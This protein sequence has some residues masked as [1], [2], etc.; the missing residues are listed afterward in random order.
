MKKLLTILLLGIFLISF[1]SA[2]EFDNVLRYEEEDMKVTIINYFNIPLLREDIGIVELK[3]HNSVDE[4]IKVGVGKRV[5][6]FYNFYNFKEIYYNGL[7]EVIFTNINTGEI[8]ERDY[9]YVY[10]TNVTEEFPIMICEEVV[11]KNGTT[12]E[13][14]QEGTKFKTREMWI[15]YNSK[16]I[17]TENIRIGIDVEVRSGDNIDGVWVIAGEEISKHAGWIAGDLLDGVRVAFQFEEASGNLVDQTGNVSSAT[18]VNV[19]YQISGALDFAYNFTGTGYVPFPDANPWDIT[20]EITINGWFNMDASI[21]TGDAP[22]IIDKGGNSGNWGLFLGYN[23]IAFVGENIITNSNETADLRGTG[24]RMA[25]VTFDDT[26]NE[27]RFYLDGVNITNVS[28][29]SAWDLTP[30][31]EDIRIGDWENGSGNRFMKG[32]IDELTIWDEVKTSEQIERLYDDGL[33]CGYGNTNCG[34]TPDDPPNINL[35]S[36]SSANYTTSQNLEINFT[37]WDDMKLDNV[38]LYVN[39]ILNQTNTSGINNTDYIFD[40]F[41]ENGDYIILGKATDNSSQSTNSSS[42]LIKIDTL[43]PQFLIQN[44]NGT[45]NYFLIGNNETLNVTFTDINLESC[46]Y[47]YNGTNITIEGCLNETKNSTVFLYELGNNNL[48]VYAND[49]L[50]NFNSTIT[51][52]DY[53]IIEINQTFNNQTLEGAPEDFLATIRLGVGETISAVGLVYNG[54]ATAGVSSVVGDNL[55]ISL[56]NLIIPQ[57]STETNITFYWSIILSGGEIINLS[58]QNQ[59]INNMGV[60]NCS[61]FSNQILNISMVDEEKQTTLSDTIIEVA[62]NLL[63]VDRTQTVVSLSGNFEDENPL[64]ICLNENITEGIMYS[65]DAILKYTSEGYAIEYYNIVNFSLNNETEILSITLY[66]LNASDSTDFQLTFNGEDFLPVEGALVFV[67]RQ[68]IAEN[69]FKTVEL[70][71]TDSKG[72][73]ILHLVR[74]DIIYNIRIIKEGSSLASFLNIIAFCQDFTIGDCTLPLNAQTNQ[75]GIFNYDNEIGILYDSPPVY[76]PTTGLV[77]FDFTS[78]SGATK[79]VNINVE[80]RDIFGNNSV[81]DNVLVSTSGT[82][83]CDAGINLSDTILFTVISIDGEEWIADTTEV[84]KTNFGSIGFV[85]WFFLAISLIL[86]FSESKNGV[87]LSVAISYIGAVTL[88]LATGTITGVGSAGVWAL[89][90]T[91]IGIWKIN[92]NR[93]T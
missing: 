29:V 32:G 75:T 9:K 42:I 19:D 40:L 91:S 84:D 1:T 30:D 54:T 82:V 68:Y 45:S 17:P 79:V 66:N 39:G 44:P 25:T 8:V 24:W 55:E 86:M 78:T 89:V 49:S 36:P 50:G 57:V 37:A 81:C 60:D 87:M 65:L 64:G 76:S 26:S 21:N 59:T 92:K 27:M 46:W 53:K 58:S 35:N 10:W 2:F 61:S 69:I 83:A 80:R 41:L 11:N 22:R 23:K 4:I 63:S 13:C 7:G 38:S 12:E 33:V 88:G 43:S 52:W 20:N 31:I 18:P 15:D 77:S 71:K 3:S 5:T 16:E 28:V 47:N 67:E 51:L 90:I 48:T 62:I 73:T 93:S 56:E 6:M 85:I 14:N 34:I 70:P 72:Q 74:N